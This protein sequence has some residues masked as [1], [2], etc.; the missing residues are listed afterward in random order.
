M[1]RL[2]R[3]CSTYCFRI[4]RWPSS[5]KA[6]ALAQKYAKDFNATVYILTSL[7]G[8]QAPPEAATWRVVGKEVDV[9]K[10]AESRLEFAQKTLAKEGITC[11]THMLIRGLEPGEDIV[12]F[13]KEVDADFIVMGIGKTSRVG[14]LFFGSNAQYAILEAS[15]PV[16]TVK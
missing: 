2:N 10:G 16:I 6:I 8:E 15:C 14:K 4:R 11:E 12:K 13:A 9:V 7:T 5:K 3:F 1:L